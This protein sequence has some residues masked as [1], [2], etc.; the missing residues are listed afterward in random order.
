MHTCT[1][2]KAVHFKYNFFLNFM[3]HFNR[4]WGRPPPQVPSLSSP[5]VLEWVSFEFSQVCHAITEVSPNNEDY[6]PFH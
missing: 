6:Q 4:H 2:V 1:S 3:P 5:L